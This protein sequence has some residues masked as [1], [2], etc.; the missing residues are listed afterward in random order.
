MKGRQTLLTQE[1]FGSVIDEMMRISPCHL[2][3]T[4]G[5]FGTPFG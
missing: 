5:S 2:A 1:N 4:T 3:Q